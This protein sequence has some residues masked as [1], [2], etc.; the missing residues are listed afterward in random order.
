MRKNK[1]IALLGGDMR[2]ISVGRRLAENGYCVNAWRVFES[3]EKE[4]NDF[5]F[6]DSIS[7]KI[8][9]WKP[10]HFPRSE[11]VSIARAKVRLTQYMFDS[12]VSS[13]IISTISSTSIF[14]LLGLL[15]IHT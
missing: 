12:N 11:S 14:L 15:Q 10:D 4:H 8:F 2:Q 3:G 9:A 1:K 6:F 5:V 7:E 13:A